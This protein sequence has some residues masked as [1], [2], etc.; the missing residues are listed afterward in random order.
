[1]LIQS[2]DQLGTVHQIPF[3]PKRIVSL[4]PSQTE[5]LFDLGLEDSMV[6][7]T[8]YCVHPADKVGLKEKIGGTKHFDLEKIKQLKPDLIIGNKEENYEEGITALRK[9]AP[10]WMSDIYTLVDSFNMMREVGRITGKEKEAID[11][12]QKIKT[13]LIPHV[14][15]NPKTCA[16]FIWRRPYMV[17]AGN[18]FIDNMLTTFGLQNAF[19]DKQRYPELTTNEIGEA[20]P[21]YIFLSSEPYAFDAKHIPEFNEICPTA[22]V[23][24]VDGEMFSW[25]GS[26]LLHAAGYFKMLRNQV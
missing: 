25:Y 9:I 5:L 13:S 7:I 24:V 14:P 11:L 12:A 10:V 15:L 21:D 3:P 18:T 6:G 22:K 17:V 19:A 8:R 2:T 26:R 20:K 16:Y 23:V 1:M 4:V